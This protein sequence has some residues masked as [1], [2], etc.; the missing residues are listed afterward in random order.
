MAVEQA[1]AD[2][3]DIISIIPTPSIPAGEPATNTFLD[4]MV[5]ENED[6]NPRASTG[7]RFLHGLLWGGASVA[8]VYGIAWWAWNAHWVNRYL[9]R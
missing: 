9:P 6:P 4:L 2:V 3:Q 8:L 7:V 5:R 1:P